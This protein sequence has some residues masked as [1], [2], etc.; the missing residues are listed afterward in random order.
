MYLTKVTKVYLYV[1]G[2]FFDRCPNPLASKESP[3]SFKFVADVANIV[4]NENIVV[5]SVSPL[6]LPFFNFFF[7]LKMH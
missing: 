4:Y 3:N 2:D 7:L 5:S 1:A 6:F